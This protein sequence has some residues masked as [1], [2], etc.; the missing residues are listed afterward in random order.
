MTD[1]FMIFII[2]LVAGILSGLLGIGGGVVLVPLMVFLLGISQHTA[3]GI[4]MVVIIPT[5]IAGILYFIRDKLVNFK[6]AGYIAFGAVLGA[7][8]SSNFV[9]YIPAADLKRLFGLF[10]IYSGI[11]MVRTKSPKEKKE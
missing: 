3:Q 1:I 8:V 9:K 11:R 2:G 5:A 10:V 6:M 4:S 7:L